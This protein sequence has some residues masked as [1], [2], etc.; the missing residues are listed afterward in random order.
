MDTW[1]R[2]WDRDLAIFIVCLI[3]RKSVRIM[4]PFLFSFNFPCSRLSDKSQIVNLN[5]KKSVTKQGSDVV[6]N[7]NSKLQHI[8]DIS[9]NKSRFVS[10][11]HSVNPLY[12]FPHLY[13]NHKLFCT[14]CDKNFM[15]LNLVIFLVGV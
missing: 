7:I 9:W 3:N 12:V 1:K 2:W 11:S 14:W 13:H 10:Q 5:S 6:E 8:S 4:L 15:R